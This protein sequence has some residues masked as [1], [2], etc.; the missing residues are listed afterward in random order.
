MDIQQKNNLAQRVAHD[1][2]EGSYVN[3]GIGL[4]TLVADYFADKEVILQ[5]ENGVLGQWTQ[6]EAGEENWDLINAG[7]EAIDLK[8]EGPFSSC[9]FFWND[10]RWTSGLLHSGCIPNFS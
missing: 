4:P 8:K 5:S 7:K 6:A 1:I 2:P 3:L 9:R 10:A